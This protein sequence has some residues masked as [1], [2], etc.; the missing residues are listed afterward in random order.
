MQHGDVDDLQSLSA[1]KVGVSEAEAAVAGVRDGSFAIGL[2]AV[3]VL[4][5]FG[6]GVRAGAKDNVL[7]E[8]VTH[9]VGCVL[10]WCNCD[11]ERLTNRLMSTRTYKEQ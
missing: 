4:L 9:Y 5:D 11:G 2:V 6:V 7:M 1:A 3:N 8:V 10:K